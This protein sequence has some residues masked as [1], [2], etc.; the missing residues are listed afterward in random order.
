M[1]INLIKCGLGNVGSVKNA[2]NK[3]GYHPNIVE[4]PDQFNYNFKKI[5]LPGVGSFDSFIASLKK[6][7]L[8]DEIIY[9]VKR[10][11]F[12]ILGIC[13]GLQSF[14]ETSEE[15]AETGLSL[16]KGRVARINSIK[17]IKVPHM[18][19]NDLIIKKNKKLLFD[20]PKKNFYFAHSYYAKCLFEEDILAYTIYDENIPAVIN[21]NNVYGVQFH[22][23]KSFLQGQ[24]ILK[25]FIEL[26]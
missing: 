20:L 15:G 26:C 13:V 23:E 22:P 4:R 17:Q 11:Q 24:K 8:F 10:Q 2:L 21:Y 1:S 9:L 6:S 7:G 5:I 14:F 19:W 16:I 18:G 3:I 25:N 12:S